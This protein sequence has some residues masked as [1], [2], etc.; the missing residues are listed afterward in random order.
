MA[1]S[2]IVKEEATDT[3]ALQ[4]QEQSY[5]T[6]CSYYWCSLRGKVSYCSMKYRG[7]TG[8]CICKKQ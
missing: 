1:T 4:K 5:C 2:N 6:D 8:F 7:P 3:I